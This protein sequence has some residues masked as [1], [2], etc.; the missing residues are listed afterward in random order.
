M[1]SLKASILMAKKKKN[2]T[3]NKEEDLPENKATE[4]HFQV[5]KLN[6]LNSL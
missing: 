2:E 3:E 4:M 6:T 1:P 5:T